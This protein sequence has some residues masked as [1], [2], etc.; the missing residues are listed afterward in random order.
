MNTSYSG[1][2]GRATY[3]AFFM[4]LKMDTVEEPYGW[5]GNLTN[6]IRKKKEKNTLPISTMGN[7]TFTVFT[8]SRS[9]L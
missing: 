6:F 9:H 4:H 3:S 1:Y 8:F 2:S 5:K 7:F